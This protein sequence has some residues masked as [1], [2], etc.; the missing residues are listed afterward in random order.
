MIASK[1]RLPRTFAAVSL[2]ALLTIALSADGRSEQHGAH[3]AS[4]VSA[5]E[6]VASVKNSTEGRIGN[7][8]IEARWPL[9]DGRPAA[10]EVRDLRDGQVLQLSGPFRIVLADGHVLEP[11]EMTL[12]APA[13]VEQLAPDPRAIVAA[14][15]FAREVGAGEIHVRE[16]GAT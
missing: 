14:E 13:R 11:A 1:G 6:A 3:P 5:G 9:H 8:A 12:F 16:G 2:S 4:A 15:R 10:L 7:R